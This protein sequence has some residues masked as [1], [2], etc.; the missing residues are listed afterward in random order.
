MIDILYSSTT[1]S[2]IGLYSATDFLSRTPQHLNTIKSLHLSW[3][4][5][6]S[7]AT[8]DQALEFEENYNPSPAEVQWEKVCHIIGTMT[9][10]AD[11]KITICNSQTSLNLL[12]RP[13]AVR[14]EKFL[15]RLSYSKNLD[16]AGTTFQ[17]IREAVTYN[18]IHPHPAVLE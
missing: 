15:E 14:I 17:V 3:I 16:T 10:L 7:H 11:V 6:S 2:F 13:W 18:I 1:F 8:G 12:Q 4:T 5:P 9:S